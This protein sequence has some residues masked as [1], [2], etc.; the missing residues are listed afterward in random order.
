MTAEAVLNP[1]LPAGGVPEAAPEPAEI[2]S[3]IMEITP[4]LAREWMDRHVKVVAANRSANGGNARDNR[5]VRWGDDGVSGYARDM[6]AGKWR[7]N[8]ETIKIARDG[9][10]P[11]GQH[12]LSACVE[13]GV[14]F[15]SLVV[16]GVEPEAQ[17]TIDIGIGRK[18]S[19]SLAIANKANPAVLA[20][21]ARWSLRWLHGV[22]GGTGGGVYKPTQQE[23]LDYIAQAPHLELAARFAVHAR[24]EFKP[25][26]HSAWGMAWLLFNGTDAL[27]ATVF[28]ERVMDG[29]DLR[30]RHP[31]L[32]FR[33]RL[34]NA[35]LN[36]E[37][38]T[39]QEQLALIIIAWNY[40]R[41][42]REMGVLKLPEGGLTAR[43]FPE[44][45]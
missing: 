32:V 27:A 36:K 8:G 11:D 12:R 22:R 7:L 40:W 37:R 25:V 30:K 34:T 19:D 21:I 45:K 18:L 6:K 41:E 39:E 4:E 2:R 31:I 23:V 42:E 3:E 29:A 5:P 35:A 24:K 15:S 28:F 1:F 26:R 13:A 10:V 43:N 44:P 16:T 20:S 17:D 33:T 38:L 14:P 9:T